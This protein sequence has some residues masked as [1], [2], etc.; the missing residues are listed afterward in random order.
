MFDF[1]MHT[2]ISFDGIGKPDETIM[3]RFKEL[4]GEIVTVGSD[5]HDA[6]R[7][8]STA[9]RAMA[10]F[11]SGIRLPANTISISTVSKCPT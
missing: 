5:A 9:G 6:P 10:L 11:G 4:G 7:V 3:R 1:H 8:G 2:D